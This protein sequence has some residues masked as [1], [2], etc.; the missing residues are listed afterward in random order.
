[1]P[2]CRADLVVGNADRR[3]TGVAQH[4][5]NL[6]AAH[7]PAGQNALGDRHP[8][9]HR[10]GLR[11]TRSPG[12]RH[13]CASRRLHGVHPRHGGHE[14]GPAQRLEPAGQSEEEVALPDGTDHGVG[15][16]AA[17]LLPDLP[18]AGRLTA[19]EERVPAVTG[20]RGGA[21]LPQAG[22]SG[23][24]PTAHDLD[25]LGPHLGDLALFSRADV[26]GYED[27]GP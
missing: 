6:V 18:R 26:R 9:V 24:T 8:L 3:P 1:M 7:R 13:G 19:E 14:P 23:G 16:R 20:V 5:E 12:L 17:E 25:D 22:R 10:D 21:G 27:P 11:P 15:H 2:L 4:P